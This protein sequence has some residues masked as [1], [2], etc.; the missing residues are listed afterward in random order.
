MSQASKGCPRCEHLC[1]DTDIKT[2]T[3]HPEQC[4]SA[5]W[6]FQYNCA[7]LRLRAVALPYPLPVSH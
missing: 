5:A 4:F 1:I 7:D 2:P 6:S 3:K